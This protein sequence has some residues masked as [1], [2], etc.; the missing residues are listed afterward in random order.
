M[1]G[2]SIHDVLGF[3]IQGTLIGIG[4]MQGLHMGIMKGFAS[5]NFV[6]GIYRDHGCYLPPLWQV[7][8][9]RDFCTYSW[10]YQKL[11]EESL[12]VLHGTS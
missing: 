7:D 5:N 11:V 6:Q 3:Q 4:V 2:G 8:P 10:G 12:T 9:D 1:G